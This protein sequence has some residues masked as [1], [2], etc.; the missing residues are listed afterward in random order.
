MVNVHL[1]KIFFHYL[2]SQKELINVV[3]D[4]FFETVDIKKVY[5]LT[6]E[7]IEKYNGIPTKF[8]IIELTKVKG[9]QEEI[10]E[11]KINSLFDVSLKEYDEDWLQ[12]T[13]EAWIEYKNLDLSVIDLIT[14]L[15]TTKV[16]VENVKDVVQNAK[17]LIT[18][19][20][21]IQFSYD[22]GL[23]FFNP[24]SHIQP[25]S[26]TFNSGIP[27]INLVLGGGWYSKALFCFM[28]EQ[29]IG[30]SIWLANIA[31]NSV[32][33]GYNTAVI[34]LEMRDR[35]VIKRLGANL[36]NISMKEYANIAQDKVSMKKKIGNLGY[37]NLQIPGKLYV[38]EFP[39]SSAGVPD[40]ERYLQKMQDIKG[41]RFKVIIVDYIN[42]LKNWRNPNSENMYMKIKQIAEDL[43]GMAM[44]NDWAI[45]TA[46]QINRCLTLDTIVNHI[47]LG[48]IPISKL[49]KNDK[50]LGPDGYTTVTEVFPVEKQKVYLIK[51]KSGKFIKASSNH[52]HPVI[53]DGVEKYLTTKELKIGDE[54]FIK[55]KKTPVL[56]YI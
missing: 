6:K 32:R 17:N 10:T 35:K 23:D 16:N 14:Y 50:I 53:S 2:L 3:N 54:F 20:N 26:D 30:K 8:Q 34:S 38:K 18:E 33:L 28:G 1:E 19:R 25:I 15:K 31:A 11:S 13:A 49:Q 37:D 43:R 51:T 40:I 12:E 48:P 56:L 41:I 9:I 36:L 47:D 46:T 42:I 24:D 27:Y 7:F 5:Q 29:K 4:R 45:I 44:R 21:N 22:E 52:I 55:N 39:T